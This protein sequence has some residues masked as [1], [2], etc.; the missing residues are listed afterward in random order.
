MKLFRYNPEAWAIQVIDTGVEFPRKPK[1]TYRAIPPVNMEIKKALNWLGP[2]DCQAAGNAMQGDIHL[3]GQPGGQYITI[4]LPF[5]EA[6]DRKWDGF[7][8]HSWKIKD[9]SFIFARRA[10]GYDQ[11]SDGEAAAIRDQTPFVIMICILPV[12]GRDLETNS[13]IRSS[14]VAL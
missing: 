4:I 7:N 13:H 12:A 14:G 3:D 2:V 5:I 11:R 9:L 8:P 10:G 1:N 6:K